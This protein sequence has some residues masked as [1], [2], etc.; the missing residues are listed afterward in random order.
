[1]TM[2][3]RS[4]DKLYVRTSHYAG[5]AGTPARLMIGLKNDGG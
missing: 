1:M 4:L 2:R 3:C 5:A